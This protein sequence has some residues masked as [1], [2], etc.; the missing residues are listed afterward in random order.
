MYKKKIL[1]FLNIDFKKDVDK[2]MMKLLTWFN[3]GFSVFVFGGGAL[4]HLIR[5]SWLDCLAL[6][7]SVLSNIFL[8][9]TI[10]FSRFPKDILV[11][12]YGV[13]MHVFSKTKN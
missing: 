1:S 13:G 6:F 2:F 11:K 9:V 4:L 12:D 3:V 8:F 5:F 10:K 7:F